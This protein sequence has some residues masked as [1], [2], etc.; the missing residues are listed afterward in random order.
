VILFERN[1][2]KI[3]ELWQKAD[4][5]SAQAREFA[6]KRMWDDAL[7]TSREALAIRVEVVRLAERKVEQL[8]YWSLITF[9]LWLL[10]VALIIALY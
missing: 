3:D 2:A 4:L 7:R 1:Q 5:L 9:F 6:A 8:S 10:I